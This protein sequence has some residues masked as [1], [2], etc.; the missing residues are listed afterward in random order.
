MMIHNHM[1]SQSM[2][3]IGVPCDF[4]FYAQARAFSMKLGRMVKIE[5]CTKTVHEARSEPGPA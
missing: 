1:H 4:E 2:R 3:N 5:V